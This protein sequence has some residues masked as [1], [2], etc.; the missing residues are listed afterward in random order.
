MKTKTTTT[1]LENLLDQSVNPKPEAAPKKKAAKPAKAAK[2]AAPAP[3]AKK[4]AA[5]P[6]KPAAKAAKPAKK[7][8]EAAPKPEGKKATILALVAR[9][10]G[11]TL[12]EIMAAAGWQ[13]H[14]VRGFISIANKNGAKIESSKNEA[15]ER[16]YRA[17]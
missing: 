2:K 11:A 7:A 9:K 6:A 10:E 15:G 3:A 17:A 8:A 5:K 16:T 13:A 14:S 4:K 12:A 1:P